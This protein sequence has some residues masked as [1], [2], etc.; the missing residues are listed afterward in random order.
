M[1]YTGQNIEIYQG[2]T[3]YIDVTVDDGSGNYVNITGCAVA[4]VVYRPTS[5]DVVLS[6]TT[7]SGVSITD[8]AGGKF[9][10]TLYPVDTENLFGQYNHEGELTDPQSNVFTL[11]TGYFKV[12][13]SKA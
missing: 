5:G 4:W 9:R 12:F 1:T 6:K 11:F 3:K 8:E 7:V 2:D 13:G 10:I